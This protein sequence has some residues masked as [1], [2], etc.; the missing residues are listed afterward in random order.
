M[1]LNVNAPIRANICGYIYL[2]KGC[3]I[4]HSLFCLYMLFFQYNNI[5]KDILTDA[6][7]PI[8]LFQICVAAIN[9]L[10][11]QLYYILKINTFYILVPIGKLLFDSRFACFAWP[12]WI[13]VKH[14]IVD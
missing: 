10:P 7:F 6:L 3:V 9:L 14:R 8:F 13:L 12:V 11:Q 4:L 2:T 1:K 5:K